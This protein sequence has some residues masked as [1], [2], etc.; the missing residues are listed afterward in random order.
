MCSKI[1]EK[2]IYKQIVEAL[3][4]NCIY[5]YQYGFQKGIGTNEAIRELVDD[6]R[7]NIHSGNINVGIFIDFKKAFDTVDHHILLKKLKGYGFIG[8]AHKWIHNYLHGRK[9]VVMINNTLSSNQ[10]VRIGVPQG[11]ILG[12]LLFLLYINDI[13]DHIFEGKLRLF[14]DDTNIFYNGTDHADITG[15]IQSDINRLDLWLRN[16]KLTVN[17][18]KCNYIII[19]SPNKRIPAMN[20][21]LQNSVLERSETVKYLGVLFDQHLTYNLTLSIFVR[22][23]V[24]VL[25]SLQE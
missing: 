12:P 7:K 8:N 18:A 15:K 10:S 4:E 1:L 13:K 24:P 22:K 17:L 23:L 9:Q 5:K 14:A 2:I 19:K 16:N 25:V 6:L 20:L 21:L 11:S 3:G